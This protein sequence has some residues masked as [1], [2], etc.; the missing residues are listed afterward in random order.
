MFWIV[1]VIRVVSILVFF[2]EAA[3]LIFAGIGMVPMPQL[4]WWFIATG[5]LGA[6]GFILTN[7]GK[8]L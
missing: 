3:R 2:L 5:F 8:P 7:L 1:N 6:G 4:P